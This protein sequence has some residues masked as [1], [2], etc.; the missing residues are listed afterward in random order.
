MERHLAQCEV[1]VVERHTRTRAHRG[2]RAVTHR[3]GQRQYPFR[4]H[5]IRVSRR[6]RAGQPPPL[7]SA[8]HTPSSRLCTHVPWAAHSPRAGGV[9]VRGCGGGGARLRHEEVLEVRRLHVPAVKSRPASA[10]S[11]AARNAGPWATAAG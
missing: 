4:S 5:R 6:A 10:A 1:E 2:A 8:C 7:P 3:T 11:S 9:R